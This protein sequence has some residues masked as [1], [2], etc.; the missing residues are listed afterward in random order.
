[1]RTEGFAH[2][3]A[4]RIDA[5]RAVAEARLARDPGDGDAL[6][7]LGIVSWR[8]G[9][10]PVAVDLLR[11]AAAALGEAEGAVLCL[12]NLTEMCRLEG[13]LDEAAAHGQRAVALGPN[14]ANAWYNLGIVEQE[15]LRLGASIAAL[16]RALA[17]AP[18]HA[19]AHFELAEALLLGGDFK[20]GWEEYEWRFRVTGVQP[21][22]PQT[23]APA[24]DGSPMRDG[25]LLLIADQGYGD[26]IQFMRFLPRARSLCP[27]VA[28]ACGS[29]MKPIVAPLAG[30]APMFD[31]WSQAPDFDAYAAFS[32]LPRL[33]GVELATIPADR[34]YLRPDAAP[35]AHWRSKLDRMTAGGPRRIGVVWAGRPTHGNDRNRSLALEQLAPL[36]QLERIALIALQ[37]GDAAAQAGRWWGG[38]PLVNLG[39]EIRDFADTAAIISTLDAVVSVDT[40][41]AHLAGALGQPTFVLLPFAPDW[42]WLLGRDDSPWYPSVRL[43]RQPSRGDW[44]APVARVAAD[45]ARP[46]RS[47][48][49]T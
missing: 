2:L 33:F 45:L 14:D 1:M 37:L 19:G 24:W 9:A 30:D 20:A 7:L 42:R 43:Y 40:S 17:L 47:R 15:R 49:A 22:L 34:A 21:L 10:Q 48:R 16:S 11:R 13:C 8:S 6:H 35:V 26:V 38:A 25:R 23:R 12:S 44:T 29:L 4:G 27:N 18:D 46:G 36:G 32:S 5:A 41:V 31:N 28:I 3:E 39:P